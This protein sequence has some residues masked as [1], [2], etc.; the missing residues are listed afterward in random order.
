MDSVSFQN[1]QTGQV[2]TGSME[3]NIT[4]TSF[5]PNYFL[6]CFFRRSTVVLTFSGSLVFIYYH[7]ASRLL[8]EFYDISGET[9]GTIHSAM[10]EVALSKFLYLHFCFMLS[11]GSL[12][13]VTVNSQLYDLE[14]T[15][16]LYRTDFDAGLSFQF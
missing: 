4:I 11:S 16:S 15:E 9:L 6:R 10:L 8:N 3:D 13:Q 1:I 7:N 2:F 5:G 12:T 14:T